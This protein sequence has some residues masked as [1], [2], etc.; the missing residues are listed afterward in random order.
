M[1]WKAS[2]PVHGQKRPPRYG[3]S[4]AKERAEQSEPEPGIA[5]LV[6]RQQEAMRALVTVVQ[7]AAVDHD[8]LLNRLHGGSGATTDRE[9]FQTTLDALW[10]R[11]FPIF[12]DSAA[13]AGAWNAVA[14]SAAAR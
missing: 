10:E 11:L 7:A 14:A 2:A 12:R 6:E 9:A 1:V 8:R 5:E 13:L 3:G 4:T